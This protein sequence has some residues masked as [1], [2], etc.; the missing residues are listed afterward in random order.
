VFSQADLVIFAP[1]RHLSVLLV[2]VVLITACTSTDSASREPESTP[3]LSPSVAASP[4]TVL[5]TEAAAWQKIRETLPAGAA[6]AV[7]TWLPASIDR[8]TVELREISASPVRYQV[9][10]RSGGRP[11]VLFISE[12]LPLPAVDAG[13][14]IHVRR[15]NATLNLPQSVFNNPAAPALRRVQWREGDQGLRIESDL[16]SSDDLERIAWSLDPSTAPPPAFPYTGSRGGGCAASTPEDTIR[17]YVALA[18]SGSGDAR[19]C[20]AREVI[21]RSPSGIWN[22][23]TTLAPRATLTGLQR[24]PDVG[25]R[26][27]LLAIWTHVSDPGGPAGQNPTFFFLLGLEEDAYR[28]F[29]TATAPLGPHY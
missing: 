29:D 28:I 10:Y 18:G 27:Q 6:I 21:E 23:W 15:S 17:R 16:L 24:R 5:L 20:Y 14:G 22:S 1:M 11:A 19:D 12:P 8:T 9:V 25:G 2:S 4:A 26:A 7:P 13:V 3:A